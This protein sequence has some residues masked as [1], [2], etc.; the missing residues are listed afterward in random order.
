MDTKNSTPCENSHIKSMTKHLK[1]E[2]S[3]WILKNRVANAKRSKIIESL[4]KS[5]VKIEKRLQTINKQLSKLQKDKNES[6]RLTFQL[7][8]KIETR[9]SAYK[10]AKGK[11]IVH[12]NEWIIQRSCEQ[13]MFEHE[14]VKTELKTEEIWGSPCLKD[15]RNQ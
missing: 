12:L 4:L 13:F 7:V 3:Y 10:K 1:H 9:E 8:N 2:K 15:S 14:Y 11:T 5:K 6:N